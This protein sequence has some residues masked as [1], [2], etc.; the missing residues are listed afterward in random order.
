MG[1]V[2]R[3]RI[4]EIGEESR[5]RILDAAEEL[6]AEQGFG[7]TSFVDVAER[8]GISRGSI[9]WHFK[10]KDGLLM[11]VLGRAVDRYMRPEQYDKSLPTLVTL[12]LGY[13]RWVR[14][15]NSALMFMV[16]TEAMSST[17]AV[18]SQYREFL[19]QRRH[20]V[21]LWLRAQRPDGV[22]PTVAAERERAV[23]VALTGALIGIHLQCLVDP[24]RV[25][26]EAALQSLATLVDTNLTDLWGESA[27][28]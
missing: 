13:A 14:S 25:H 3:R 1:S 2:G 8:S 28:S 16:L 6:F 26:L 10:N 17:G 21:E 9:P 20:G 11:A 19:D 27:G 23:A 5:R 24:D 18:H 12:L 4:D 22:D 15:G 7:R